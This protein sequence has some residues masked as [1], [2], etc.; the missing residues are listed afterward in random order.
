MEAIHEMRVYCRSVTCAPATAKLTLHFSVDKSHRVLK[1]TA[2]SQK[3]GVAS[4]P[5]HVKVLL[6]W[7]KAYFTV[8]LTMSRND[9][10]MS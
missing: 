5:T 3:Y 8:I 10:K 4:V 6:K 1:Y 2:N 7:W 9:V